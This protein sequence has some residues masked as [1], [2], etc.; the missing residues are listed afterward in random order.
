MK[1][2]SIQNAGKKKAA[3]RK[4]RG[5]TDSAKRQMHQK[6]NPGPEKKIPKTGRVTKKSL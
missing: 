4:K 2:S 3:E 1:S 6:I 5:N